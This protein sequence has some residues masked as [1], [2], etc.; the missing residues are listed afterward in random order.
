MNDDSYL[1]FLFEENQ[2]ISNSFSALLSITIYVAVIFLP[3]IY[4]YFFDEEYENDYVDTNYIE[5]ALQ[6]VTSSFGE[7]FDGIIDILNTL[8]LRPVRFD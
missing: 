7:A 4:D 5:L 8:L 2:S 3:M 6:Y 1:F